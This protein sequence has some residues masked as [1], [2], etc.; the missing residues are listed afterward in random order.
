MQPG[1]SSAAL[2]W[3]LAYSRCLPGLPGPAPGCLGWPPMDSHPPPPSLPHCRHQ[4]TTDQRTRPPSASY[5]RRDEVNTNTNNQSSP[6]AGR[7][8]VL[9]CLISSTRICFTVFLHFFL[10]VCFEGPFPG[11]LDDCTAHS[12]AANSLQL[13]PH[14][15]NLTFPTQPTTC[16]I[17]TSSSRILGTLP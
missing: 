8:S 4:T 17:H 2:S 14:V 10:K 15:T 12:T 3:S 13:H 7:D 9:H 1:P 16:G 11:P 5:S 6:A